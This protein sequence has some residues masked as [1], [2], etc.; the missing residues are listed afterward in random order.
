MERDRSLVQGE[1]SIAD[2]FLIQVAEVKGVNE[3]CIFC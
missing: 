1:M 3:L 2:D